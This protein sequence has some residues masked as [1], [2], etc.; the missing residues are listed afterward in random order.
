MKALLLGAIG[1]YRRYL[2]PLKAPTCRF[3]PTCSGYALEAI[4]RFGPLYGTWLTVRRVLR[5]HP[6][7]AGGWDPVPERSG[8]NR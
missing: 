2:S 8:G 6:F 3:Q 4:E 5:C 7:H 1:L